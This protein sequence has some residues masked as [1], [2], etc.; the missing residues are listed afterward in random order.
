MSKEIVALGALCEFQ[1]APGIT[2]AEEQ[3]NGSGS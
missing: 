2:G 3:Q 1:M